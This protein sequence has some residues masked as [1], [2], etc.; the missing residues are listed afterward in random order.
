MLKLYNTLTRKK[1]IFKPLNKKEVGLYSCGPTVYHYAHLGN[2]R[3]YIFADI[4]KKTLLFNGFNVKHVINITD[5]GHLTSDADTGED[6]LEKG[7]KRE[8]K[9]A[10]D[11]AEFYT[12]AFQEDMK[13][14]NILPP[15][16]ICKAT[17][18][19]KEQIALVKTLEQKGYTYEIE[20]GIYFD[21]SKLKD[22]GKLAKLKLKELKAGARID[23]K[24]KKNPTDFALWKFSPKD[25]KR[26]MEWISPWSKRGFPGWHVECSAMSMKYLGNHFDMHTGGIDHIPVHHTNEIA[27]SESA[28]GEKFVNYWLHA[29]FLVLKDNVK[30]GKSNDNFL[31][32]QTLLD[33]GYDPLDYRYFCLTTQYK[34]PLA[35]GFEGVDAARNARLHLSEKIK[36]WLRDPSSKG[37]IRIYKEKFLKAIN[38]DL[39]TPKALALV[40]EIVKTTKLGNK[41]KLELL[42]DFDKVLGLKLSEITLEKIPKEIESLAKKRQLLRKEKKFQEADNVR[43]QIQEKGY[44]LDDTD[45][46]VIIKKRS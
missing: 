28:T 1:E 5:V 2:L 35:F 40:W 31:R 41:Q 44:T 36:E 7:A 27:Q 46:G 12:K 26:D 29:E 39:N 3:A 16:I 45:K 43:K 33:K 32:L 25:Q 20:D 37:E 6:K 17:D 18:H 15:T 42:L 14:L 9:T 8:G 19:I 30:M 11:V 13:L 38:D 10:W 34:I 21:T 22:Y 4:L 24:D 23:V